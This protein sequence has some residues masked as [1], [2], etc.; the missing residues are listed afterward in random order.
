M[1]KVIAIII[2]LVCVCS[3]I[4]INLKY[5]EIENEN[6]ES[7]TLEFVNIG[8][9]RDGFNDT[10]FIGFRD[11]GT[12]YYYCACGN[13]V[14]DSDLCESYTYDANEN[15]IRLNCEDIAETTI[16]E[17]KIVSYE[18]NKL[19]LD[20]NGDIREFGRDVDE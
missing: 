13:P 2:M 8:W 11:D 19:V 7:D 1:K 4:F 6:I 3:S 16:T 10:E 20:F 14:N 12:F 15:T 5:N 18:E 9:T 17:I